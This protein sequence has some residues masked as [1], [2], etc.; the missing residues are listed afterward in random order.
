MA[1]QVASFG[2]CVPLEGITI[3]RIVIGSLVVA[4]NWTQPVGNF[5]RDALAE[6]NRPVV[7]HEHT[8]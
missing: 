6:A 4:L 1:T 7:N 8:A 3:A 2:Q 5:L